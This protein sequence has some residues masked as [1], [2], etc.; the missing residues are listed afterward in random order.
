MI[1]VLFVCTGNICRSP[2]AEGVFRKRLREEGLTDRVDVDSAGTEDYHTGE[3]PDPRAQ[4]EAKRRGID[5]GGQIAR[6]VREEDLETYHYVVAMDPGHVQYLQMLRPGNPIAQVS[7]L[8]DF[9]PHLGAREVPDPYF[10][11]RR[12]FERVYA[13]IEA[14]MDGLIADIKKRLATTHAGGT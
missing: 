9:A 3:S 8:T 2:T 4:Q 13:L 1:K 6:H 5:I 14:C 10:G 7:L 11:G 12:G